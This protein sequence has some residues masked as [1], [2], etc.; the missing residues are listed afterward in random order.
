MENERLKKYVDDAIITLEQL[1]MSFRVIV[2]NIE[3]NDQNKKF[4]GKV[5][6]YFEIVE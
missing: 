1:S 2:E 3:E 6:V 5:N 4:E